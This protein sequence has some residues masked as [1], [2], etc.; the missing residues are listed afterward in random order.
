M[1]SPQELPDVEGEDAKTG[2]K[3]TRKAADDEPFSALAFKI[4]TDP[5]VGQ[6]TFFR[7]YSGVLRSGDTILNV[8]KGKKERIGRILQMH[9]NKREEIKE[10]YAGNIA[11]A[12]GL[13]T[14]TTG[15]TLAPI[16]Q[17][18]VLERMELLRARRAGALRA[19]P[20]GWCSPAPPSFRRGGLFTRG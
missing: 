15:D 14:C 19:E 12:V 13:K 1:C 16:D 2:E 3:L 8:A 11:A 10:V 20:R 17:P 4:M 6:L 18:I 5:F 7:V 9:S